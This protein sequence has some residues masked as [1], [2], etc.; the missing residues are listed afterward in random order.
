MTETA[1]GRA[2]ESAHQ[3]YEGAIEVE[4]TG[5]YV[6]ARDVLEVELTPVDGSDWPDHAAGAHV[7]VQLPNGLLRQYSLVAPSAGQR[8]NRVAVLKTADSRGG[9][10]FIHERL[11]LGHRILVSEPKNNFALVEGEHVVLVAGGIG[12]TPLLAMARELAAAGRSFEFHYQVRT[13]DRAAYRAE[14]HELVPEGQLFV[15]SD[16][17]DGFF[18]PET[19]FAST[20]ANAE[21]YVCGPEAFMEH[22]IKGAEAAGL[23]PVHVEHFKHEADTEGRPFVLKAANSGLTLEVGANQTPFEVLDAAGVF[24]P[25]ACEQ[26][27]CGTCVVR[28]LEG[29]PDHRDVVLSASE[30][31]AGK[32][33]ALCCSRSLT[34]EL[35]V[36][37]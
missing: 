36:E 9:S 22:V 13:P 37:I 31:A 14:L 27:V 6:T 32:T 19:V 18:N 23:G 26:G 24:V 10:E 34:P 2:A 3:Q 15:R 35:V 5:R 25:T 1:V 11:A 17:E 4:V 8:S 28:V 16:S 7:D 21:V 33:V 29:T 20:S 30:K 12:V